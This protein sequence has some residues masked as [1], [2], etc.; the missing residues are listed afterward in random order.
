MMPFF[1]KGIKRN[2]QIMETSN[3][4]VVHEI[5]SIRSEIKKQQIS[6][7]VVPSDLLEKIEPVL[8]KVEE[9]LKQDDDAKP[10]LEEIVTMIKQMKENINAKFE[11]STQ[12]FKKWDKTLENVADHVKNLDK[13]LQGVEKDLKT[14]KK[15]AEGLAF[16]QIT[17]LFEQELAK[18]V[19]PKGTD[20]GTIDVYKKM[21]KWLKK[22]KSGKEKEAGRMATD[23]L[24][25]V[26]RKMNWNEE[27]HEEVLKYFKKYRLPFA[28]PEDVNLEDAKIQINDHRLSDEEKK[29]CLD[30]INIIEELRR[31]N[32]DKQSRKREQSPSSSCSSTQ[33]KKKKFVHP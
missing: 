15:I 17:F 21:L 9:V 5:G 28:H 33:K 12:M 26:K 29:G 3:L 27:L 31:Y 32:S 6:Q 8:K 11:S 22:E 20:V 1:F 23:R 24:E 7:E 18:Y 16:G 30:I 4:H 19:L 13:R 14:L 10:L 2:Q 25:Y